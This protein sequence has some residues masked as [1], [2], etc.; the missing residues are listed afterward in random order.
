ML[1]FSTHM[2]NEFKCYVRLH[3]CICWQPVEFS[4][5][6]YDCKVRAHQLIF[7]FHTRSIVIVHIIMGPVQMLLLGTIA[8]RM[9]AVITTKVGEMPGKSRPDAV[10]TSKSDSIEPQKSEFRK[11]GV[12]RAA[13]LIPGPPKEDS[14]PDYND[15]SW[16][17]LLQNTYQLALN[18]VYGREFIPKEEV[19]LLYYY[20]KKHPNIKD[21]EWLEHVQATWSSLDEVAENILEDDPEYVNNKHKHTAEDN[22]EHN[23]KKKPEQ[24]HSSSKHNADD[25]REQNAKNKLAHHAAD[26]HGHSG[27]DKGGQKPVDKPK[28]IQRRI[29]FFVHGFLSGPAIIKEYAENYL[30]IEDVHFIGINWER[31]SSDSAS[32]V[33]AR[34]R[35]IEVWTNTISDPLFQVFR[36]YY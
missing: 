23:V 33:V 28:R 9:S 15:P 34:D 19:K 13:P 18:S 5:Q 1:M 31:G 24:H 16:M 35:V 30:R 14:F 27:K 8:L 32:Y 3:Y 36:F 21:G 7:E 22:H 20:R 11:Q 12:R 29:I 2:F 10:V 17:G 25:N 4:L 6:N 26:M